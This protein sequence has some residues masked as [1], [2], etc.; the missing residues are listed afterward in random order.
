MKK[1][2]AVL[3]A[4][5]LCLIFFDCAKKDD[6][7]EGEKKNDTPASES[8]PAE[9]KDVD[10]AELEAFLAEHG[11][12]L[13]EASPLPEDAEFSLEDGNTV[14]ITAKRRSE[15]TEEQ[16]EQIEKDYEEQEANLVMTLSPLY[17]GIDKEFNADALTVML[18]FVDAND[19]VFLERELDFSVLPRTMKE[20]RNSSLWDTLFSDD[21]ETTHVE[22]FVSSVDVEGEDSLLFLFTAE[23]ELT[24]EE[25]A[26][27]KEEAQTEFGASTVEDELGDSLFKPIQDIT[28]ISHMDVIFRFVE[29]DGSLIYEST[30]SFGD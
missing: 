12:E 22:G 10:A 26:A 9:T 30:V 16:K 24:E 17:R 15:V 6:D 8:A 20:L 25:I 29:T 1:I 13:L 4:M 14:V 23:Q 19:K 3:L 7:K 5:S 2:L 21:E 28:L 27:L 18:R 11:E